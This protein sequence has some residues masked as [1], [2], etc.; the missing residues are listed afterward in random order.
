MDVSK[1]VVPDEGVDHLS[2]SAA[3]VGLA[4][5]AFYTQSILTILWIVKG[6]GTIWRISLMKQHIYLTVFAALCTY[7]ADRETFLL[8]RAG[9]CLFR[10]EITSWFLWSVCVC[11]YLYKKKKE[12]ENKK[13]PGQRS[14]L[15]LKPL[16][17]LVSCCP[18]SIPV[19]AD[20]ISPLS[21]G[22][23]DN[24]LKGI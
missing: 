8:E 12:K 23:L 5:A 14:V 24:K 2:H 17:S 22:I 9:V 15:Y 6:C 18:L 3:S 1:S 4:W 11:L 16:F 19:G 7:S 20:R 10:Q 21:K 13:R